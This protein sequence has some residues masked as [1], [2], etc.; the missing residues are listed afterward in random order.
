MTLFARL[1]LIVVTILDVV[2]VAI[3]N[4]HDRYAQK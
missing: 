2:N 1:N 3:M 4:N